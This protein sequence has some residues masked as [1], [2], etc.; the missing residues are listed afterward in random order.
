MGRGDGTP[1]NLRRLSRNTSK[2]AYSSRTQEPHDV[3]RGRMSENLFKEVI[4]VL[5]FLFRGLAET[6]KGPIKLIIHKEEYTGRYVYGNLVYQAVDK[7]QKCFIHEIPLD[8]PVIEEFNLIEVIPAFICPASPFLDLNGNPIFETDVVKTTASVNTEDGPIQWVDIGTMVRDILGK[9]NIE[10]V[11]NPEEPT[12]SN[13]LDLI[14]ERFGRIN[15]K[16]EVLGCCFEPETQKRTLCNSD[17]PLI[18]AEFIPRNT[19]SS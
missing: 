15:Y 18:S 2:R 11:Y 1:L 13:I 10:L 16:I 9:W 5:P 4:V 19:L 8:G 12:N 3:S 6:P 14:R 7:K 17:S